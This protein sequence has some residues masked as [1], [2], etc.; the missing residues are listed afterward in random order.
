[1]NFLDAKPAGDGFWDVAGV[2]VPGPASNQQKLRFAIRPE[3]IIVHPTSTATASTDQAPVFSA[4]VRIL[5]PLG[6]HLLASC[7]VDDQMLRVVL[8]SDAIVKPGDELRWSPV[9]G[10]VRWFD[11]ETELAVAAA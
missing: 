3:D 2:R 1:M 9:D 8:E 6:S 10:R 5:E 4:T 11:P 7:K